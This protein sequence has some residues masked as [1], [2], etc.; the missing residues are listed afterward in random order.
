MRTVLRL[1][2]LGFH[3]VKTDT[4]TVKVFY[5]GRQI[6]HGATMAQAR[7]LADDYYTALVG[8]GHP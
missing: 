7:K 6:A 1:R 4:D 8:H 2:Q 5:A 3:F